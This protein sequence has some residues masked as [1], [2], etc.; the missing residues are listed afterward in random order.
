MVRERSFSNN[1]LISDFEAIENL[2]RSPELKEG[3]GLGKVEKE[4]EQIEENK[5]SKKIIFITGIQGCGKGTQSSE[6]VK[7]FGYKHVTTGGIVRDAA[8]KD[9]ELK[10][11][12][13]AGELVGMDLIYSSLMDEIENGDSQKIIIDGFPR[14]LE[15]AHSFNE[16]L[17]KYDCC[18]LNIEISEKVAEERMFARNRGD[19]NKVA[20]KNRINTFISETLPAIDHL[21]KNVN[22][23]V[24]INGEQSKEAV[25]EDISSHV[26]K[27]ELESSLTITER[28]ENGFQSKE[29]VRRNQKDVQN[30]L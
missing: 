17:S 5:Q 22:Y 21:A 9:S 12:M 18:L 23:A 3:R 19:D 1:F 30:S 16:V 8:A 10:A 20:I 25:F 7:K 26:E 6:T 2:K 15:Q 4:F 27:F 24:T 14:T 13:E 11:R 29:R 28:M